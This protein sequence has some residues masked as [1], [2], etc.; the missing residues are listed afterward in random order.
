MAVRGWVTE[1]HLTRQLAQVPGVKNC[2]RNDEDG[3]A[4]VLLDFE[5]TPLSV[6]CKNVLRTTQ[7]DGLPRVDF[8]RTRASKHD[9]YSRFYSPKD[10]DVLAACLNAITQKWEYRFRPTASMSP[11]SKC[12]EKLSNRVKV[13]DAWTN[14][15]RNALG[16]AARLKP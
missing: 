1:E 4:D 15:A 13:D 3:G 2:T 5:G 10:F 16:A 11:H 9:P 7:S 12:P 8:Q 6:E 14:D